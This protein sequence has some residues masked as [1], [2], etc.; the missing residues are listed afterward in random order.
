MHLVDS[1]KSFVYSTTKLFG[2]DNKKYGYCWQM[3][4]VD[5]TKSF[6]YTPTKLFGWD[7]K[8]YVY[9]WQLQQIFCNALH[10]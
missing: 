7:N 5:T 9:C 1:T 6:V 3:H 10:W 8:K 4:L 2:W